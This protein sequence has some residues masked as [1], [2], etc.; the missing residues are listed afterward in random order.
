MFKE[1][2]NNSAEFGLT[3]F[4]LQPNYESDGENDN[5]NEEK[6][7]KDEDTCIVCEN[8][9]NKVGGGIMVGV[10]SYCNVCKDNKDK[11]VENDK[12]VDTV[13]SFLMQMSS[14]NSEDYIAEFRGFSYRLDK[15]ASETKATRFVACL[16]TIQEKIYLY[17]QYSGILT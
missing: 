12:N 3:E 5:S 14:Q 11:K 15:T 16:E 13:R 7:V 17:D 1:T 9:F 8:K 2:E 4:D 10:L 6:S